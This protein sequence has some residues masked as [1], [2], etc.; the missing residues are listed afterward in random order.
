M[1]RAEGAAAEDDLTGGLYL[2]HPAL[3]A[4]AQAGGALAVEEHPLGRGLADHGQVGAPERRKEIGRRD[5]AP[6]APVGAVEILRHLKE[7]RALLPGTVEI[8]V[9]GDLQ[10]FAGGDERLRDGARGVLV[11]HLKRAVLPVEIIRQA[12]VALGQ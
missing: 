6:F 3:A 5:R 4:I 11:R 2:L 12:R 8:G 1:R 9:A 7:T 10:A